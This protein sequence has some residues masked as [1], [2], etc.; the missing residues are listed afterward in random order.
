ML[1]IDEK[2]EH[3]KK[4]MKAYR[5]IYWPKYYTLNKDAIKEKNKKYYYKNRRRMVSRSK[6]WNLK[7]PTKW[8]D[9]YLKRKYGVSLETYFV[10]FEEQK[11]RCALCGEAL[12]HG[13]STCLDHDH[14]SGKVRGL[15]HRR[16][17]L[18]LGF[19]K[20]SISIL[21]KAVSY[22]KRNEKFGDIK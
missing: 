9:A 10:L 16:C 17:N 20:D 4:Y 12:A 6:E 15:V 19:A 11:G 1:V 22:L 5:K 14:A 7:N 13:Q 18:L 21:E 3:V 2:K 8:K